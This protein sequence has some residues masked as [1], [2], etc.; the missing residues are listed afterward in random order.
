MI[1]GDICTRSCRFCAVKTGKPTGV[2]AD[3][4]KRVARLVSELEVTYVVITSVD[5]DDLP[6][7]GA[8]HW[9]ETINLVKNAGIE[10]EA[11]VPDFGGDTAA[12]DTVLDSGP[13]V[14]SH[15]IETV[16][17]LQHIARPQA[18]YMRS[19]QL[20]RRSADRGLLTK[21]GFMVGLGET[22]AQVEETLSDLADNGTSLVAVGQY[23]Q[24]RTDLLPVKV[25]WSPEEFSRIE[26]I[27]RRLGLSVLAGPMVRSSYRADELAH[28]AMGTL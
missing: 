22:M 28:G 27:G 23:L 15:N 4:P 8:A 12:Q 13:S 19:M 11:L 6:D 14:F 5:R 3:E 10:V 1:L 7:G 21:S 9:A 2:D 26:E 17:A 20:L 16:K 25:Y 24:P 18:D